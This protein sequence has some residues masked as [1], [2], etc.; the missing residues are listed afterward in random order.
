MAALD[1]LL[2]RLDDSSLMVLR[3]MAADTT[4][5]LRWVAEG[6][7]EEDGCRGTLGGRAEG[8]RTSVSVCILDKSNVRSIL[9]LAGVETLGACFG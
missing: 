8:G 7:L 9:L 2:L 1:R 5:R 6:R 3:L 4:L